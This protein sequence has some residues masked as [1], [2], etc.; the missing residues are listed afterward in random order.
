VCSTPNNSPGGPQW[1]PTF[2]GK[3]CLL[4]LQ[5]PCCGVLSAGPMLSRRISRQTHQLVYECKQLCFDIM[6]DLIEV[7][8]MWIPSHVGLVGNELVD[9]EARFAHSILPRVS[10]RPWFEGQKDEKGFVTSVSRIMSG[11]GSVR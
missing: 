4:E 10:L 7:K 2:A 5:I 8:I 11:H 1:H 9:G 6:R 3:I